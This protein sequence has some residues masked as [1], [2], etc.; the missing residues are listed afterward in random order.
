MLAE[1]R[2]GL[3]RPAAT[4]W[5]LMLAMAWLLPQLVPP[6]VE[7]KTSMPPPWK[8]NDDGAVRLN[9]RLAAETARA[10]GRGE[11]GAPGF[12]AIARN[13]HQNVAGAVGLIP[14]G[15]AVTVVGAGRSVVADGPVLV[16]EVCLV[17]DD[18]IAPVQ[19]VVERLTATSPMMPE[20]N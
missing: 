13:A 1:G 14:L 19:S 11:A 8:G 12:S 9:Q 10:I 16:V 4:K 15:V 7:L 17:D 3:R 5:L 6:L 2:L 20:E 18:G